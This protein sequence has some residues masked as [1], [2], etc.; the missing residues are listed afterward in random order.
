MAR[1]RDTGETSH[2]EKD[3]QM[4]RG[5]DTGETSHTEK[6]LQMARGGDTGDTCR[7]ERFHVPVRRPPPPWISA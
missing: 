1:G 2:T 6:D 5:R 7:S 4:A 3:L